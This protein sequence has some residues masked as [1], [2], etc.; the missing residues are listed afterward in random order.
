MALGGDVWLSV[1]AISYGLTVVRA[2]RWE[3]TLQYMCEPASHFMALLA[4]MVFHCP[5]YINVCFQVI[6]NLT[7]YI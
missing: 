1:S 4:L 7:R 3:L 5:V 2:E 6:R